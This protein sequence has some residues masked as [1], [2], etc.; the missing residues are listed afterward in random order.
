MVVE[1]QRLG[2]EVVAG[3]KTPAVLML[4]ISTRSCWQTL[5]RTL[6]LREF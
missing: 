2:S 4:A 5:V 6:M 1:E 3:L